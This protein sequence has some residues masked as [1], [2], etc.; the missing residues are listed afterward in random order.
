MKNSFAR[1]ALDSNEYLKL[2]RENPSQICGLIRNIVVCD[3]DELQS[4]YLYLLEAAQNYDSSKNINM[5]TYICET[6]R[7][8]IRSIRK[9]ERRRLLSQ[10]G[11]KFDVSDNTINSIDKIY[12]QEIISSINKEPDKRLRSIL[13]MF[14]LQDKTL[15]EIGSELGISHEYVR[16]LKNRWIQLHRQRLAV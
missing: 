12:I 5:S 15:T 3:D 8:R 4:L 13:E 10:I 2:L 16:L 6:V 11:E 9:A 1:V 14:F 7:L